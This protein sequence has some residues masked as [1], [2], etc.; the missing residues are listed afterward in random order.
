MWT[1]GTRVVG[2]RA[3]SSMPEAELSVSKIAPSTLIAWSKLAD[4]DVAIGQ[5][6]DK[7][8]SRACRRRRRRAWPPA[9]RPGWPKSVESTT[10]EA[11]GSSSR[12][13]GWARLVAQPLSLGVP[14]RPEPPVP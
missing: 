4:G 1:A 7:S 3:A 2:A 6:P 11:T 13:S 9:R 10:V 12:G 14:N 8:A 5:P